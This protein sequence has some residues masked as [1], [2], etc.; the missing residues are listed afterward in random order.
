[1]DASSSGRAQLQNQT[2]E[3]L[4]KSTNLQKVNKDENWTFVH[5]RYDCKIP[6]TSFLSKYSSS[7]NTRTFSMTLLVSRVFSF[8]NKHMRH[9]ARPRCVT[10]RIDFV[11]PA[12]WEMRAN[13]ISEVIENK[14]WIRLTWKLIRIQRWRELLRFFHLFLNTV[15]VLEY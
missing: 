6:P 1:M 4:L 13:E 5:I 3:Q 8:S 15:H 14:K 7:R 9:V 11:L 10:S 2:R 12:E